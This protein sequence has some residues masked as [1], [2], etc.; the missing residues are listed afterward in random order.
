MPGK[1][2]AKHRHSFLGSS[3]RCW[4]VVAGF[5][6]TKAPRFALPFLI[7]LTLAIDLFGVGSA[8]RLQSEET[9]L[10]LT[11]PWYGA[12]AQQAVT[13]ILIDDDFVSHD[14]ADGVGGGTWPM[15]YARYA[16][17]IEQLIPMQPRVILLDITFQWPHADT[18]DSIV[19]LIEALQLANENRIRIVIARAAMPAGQPGH[20]FCDGRDDA[21]A[22]TFNE[23]PIVEPL[24]AAV[25][26]SNGAM[27]FAT[28]SNFGCQHYYPLLIAPALASPAYEL[29]KILCGGPDRQENCGPWLS[30][31]AA[32][33][34]D[35]LPKPLL[36]RWGAFPSPER[37]ARGVIS[38]RSACDESQGTERNTSLEMLR[39]DLRASFDQ[40]FEWS[41]TRGN[42]LLC[43]YIEEVFASTLMQSPQLVEHLVRDRAVLI[44]VA[45]SVAWDVAANPVN[46]SVPGVI[47]H[48]AA[49]ENLIGLG[50]H[51]VKGFD[52][53]AVVWIEV[54][55]VGVG[56]GLYE[57]FI[58]RATRPKKARIKLR[59]DRLGRMVGILLIATIALLVRPQPAIS[60][61][62]A[63]VLALWILLKP[64]AL[65]LTTLYAVVG[66]VLVFLLLHFGWGPVNWIGVLLAVMAH[67]I[68]HSIEGKEHGSYEKS[69]E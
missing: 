50:R 2:S 12:P 67:V 45:P 63:T 24:E 7:T 29:A 65:F 58:H 25:K 3:A 18:R 33:E 5:L 19:P 22:V 39:R 61:I 38:D 54:G 40:A 44:G 43:H 23:S 49:T 32:P 6:Q 57:V 30:E 35:E 51:Y 1:S 9:A 28:V 42:R 15:P 47:V 37:V 60:M 10:R 56:I 26:R 69:A 41:S 68:P 34:S 17:M 59:L 4:R 62:V 36:I 16:D 21:G 55:L 11:A 27:Q 14:P 66:I 20:V 48:A 46:G 52:E 31:P 8:T 64:A 53:R 13:A